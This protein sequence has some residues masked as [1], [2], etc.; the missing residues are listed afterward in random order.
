MAFCD[1]RYALYVLLGDAARLPLWRRE[2]WRLAVP[3]LDALVR[4]AG[5]PALRT[6]QREPDG[7]PAHIGRIGWSERGHRAW[8]IDPRR[9]PQRLFE[10]AELWAPSWTTSQR[11]GR[12]P[13]VYLAL[14]NE[15]ACGELNGRAPPAFNPTVLL[16][17]AEDLAD[18]QRRGGEHAAVGLAALLGAPLAAHQRQRPWGTPWGH[19]GYTDGIQDLLGPALFRAGSPHARPVD[20]ATLVGSWQPI[21]LQASGFGPRDGSCRS[22]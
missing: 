22:P 8:T 5:R 12:P 7:S 10:A 21:G 16:A 20:L 14:R 1:R 9:T 13:A 18:E 3:L 6:L 17:V 15:E 11:D 4:A 2:R 19:E